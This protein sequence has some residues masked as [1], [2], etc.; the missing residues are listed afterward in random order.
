M[1]PTAALREL[2]RAAPV[3][4]EWLGYEGAFGY[5]PLREAIAAHMRARGVPAQPENVLLLAG[6]QQGLYLICRG[7]LQA[8]DTVVVEAPS[9]LLTLGVLQMAGLRVLRAPLDQHGLIPDQLEALLARH[10]VAMIFTVPAYQNPTSAV[11]APSRRTA[12]LDLC[13][14]Y[15][16][17]LVEDD[18]YGELGFDGISPTPL[19]ALDAGS[20]VIYVGSISKSVSPGLRAGWLI[21]PP[22]LVKRL[23]EMK[24]HMHYGSSIVPEWVAQ[25]WLAQGYHAAHI[26]RTAQALRARRDILE[27]E[28]RQQFGPL[29]SWLPPRGGFHLWA[30]VNAPISSTS[31]FR[32]ALREGIGIKPGSL[33]GVPAHQCWIRLSFQHASPD[34]LRAVPSTLRRVVDELIRDGQD[35]DLL[36]SEAAG[37]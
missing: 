33:Y 31:L 16:V 23:A 25:Q 3:T 9:Y 5:Q 8:G 24:Y 1:R 37:I 7:L 29:L 27:A 32:R 21:G 34:D 17:P 10:R 4:E 20:Y 28:L 12:L 2:F 36:G 22:H 15:R 13:E 11:L 26:T 35:P 6:A 18:V 19:Y 14:Q 30:R